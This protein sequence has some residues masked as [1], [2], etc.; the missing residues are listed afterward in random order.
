MLELQYVKFVQLK[1]RVAEEFCYDW[2]NLLSE[3]MKL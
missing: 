2:F 1:Y 3:N